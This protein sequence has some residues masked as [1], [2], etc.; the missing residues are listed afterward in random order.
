MTDAKKYSIVVFVLLTALAIISCAMVFPAAAVAEDTATGDYMVNSGSTLTLYSNEPNSVPEPLFEV[1]GT[2]YVTLTSSTPSAGYYPVTYNGA[3]Y[4]VSAADF[5]SRVTLHDTEKYGAV[6]AEN[7]S[8][9]PSA[10]EV[11][12]QG[13]YN[14]F[15]Y[16]NGSISTSS[17]SVNADEISQLYGLFTVQNTSY[18]RVFV[19]TTIFGRPY[20]EYVYIPAAEAAAPYSSYTAATV[21]TNE[22]ESVKAEIDK[23]LAEN[24]N[25]P[26]DEEGSAS[27]TDPEN[28]DNNLE[29]IILSVI[30]AILCVAVVLLIFRPGKKKKA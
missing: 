25:P 7:K 1:P 13:P 20:E 30:I 4:Y 10:S 23:Q 5:Q 8:Y 26:G 18:Y 15:T 22:Y 19:Q 9:A 2:Y 14:A 28:P 3:N 17:S 16:S 21:P 11:F 12:P 24:Q 27:T 6:P 29:R